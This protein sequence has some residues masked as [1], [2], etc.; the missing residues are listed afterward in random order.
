MITLN[1]SVLKAAVLFVSNEAA[2]Y[3]ICGVAVQC[4]DG[5]GNVVATSG[6]VLFA[7]RFDVDK[8][9]STDLVIPTDALQSALKGFKGAFLELAPAGDL[10][11]LGNTLFAPIDGT[12]PAW[13]RVLPA[14]LSGEVAQ[15]DSALI[16][17]LGKASKAM[18]GSTFVPIKHNGTA[19]AIA[20][21]D[22]FVEH[23]AFAVIAPKVG[24][25]P[26]AESLIAE[27]TNTPAPKPEKKAP[28]QMAAE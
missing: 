2:R 18:G 22:T 3:Y 16:T 6:T 25:A 5:V 15:F 24:A 19:P 8:E 4:A 26:D 12:F 7:S 9:I 17:I 11:R 14:K 27:V 1:T 20:A 23:R 28:E 21:N 10:W 13:R